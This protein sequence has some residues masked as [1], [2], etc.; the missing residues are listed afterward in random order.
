MIMG[1]W[2]TSTFTITCFLPQ[3]GTLLCCAWSWP[4][5]WMLSRSAW[6]L[7]SDDIY[8]NNL[9]F[10]ETVI[11]VPAGLGTGDGAEQWASGQT[12]TPSWCLAHPRAEGHLPDEEG[13]WRRRSKSIISLVR[14]IQSSI[15][16]FLFQFLISKSVSTQLFMIYIIRYRSN[17]DVLKI[18]FMIIVVAH[19]QRGWF[20]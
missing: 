6:T 20:S 12:G 4:H 19:T 8:L 13:S 17:N 9:K 14:N 11:Q 5:L 3:T 15:L 18:E 7:E 10:D 1:L 16:A 2:V